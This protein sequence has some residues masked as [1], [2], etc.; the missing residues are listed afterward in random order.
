LARRSAPKSR[1]RR[2]ICV[3]RPCCGRG[4]ACGIDRFALFKFSFNVNFIFS[5]N[6]SFTFRFSF[7]FFRYVR[8]SRSSWPGIA[9]RRRANALAS[10]S[11]TSFFASAKRRKTWMPGTR[12][13]MTED[14][15]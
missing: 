7:R 3:P 6:C 1:G 9:R 4:R 13:R 5:L 10:L 12:P 2:N 11:S 15:T 8:C 14:A